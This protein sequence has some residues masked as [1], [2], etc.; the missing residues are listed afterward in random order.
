MS[1]LIGIL[2]DLDGTL[3]NTLADIAG[4]VNLVRQQY[5]LKRLTTEVVKGYI[6][7]G[8]DHLIKHSFQDLSTFDPTSLHKQV[9][10]TYLANPHLG[11]HVYPGVKEMLAKLRA[12]PHLKL[13]IAT[14]KP[15]D[16]A[17]KTL[18][19]Y[20]PET[21]FEV[22]AG[23]EKVSEKKPSPIHLLEVIER[24]NLTPQ[25]AVYVGDDP[26]DAQCAQAAGVSFYA[27]GWGYGGVKVTKERYLARP[28][29]LLAKLTFKH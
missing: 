12:N 19:Y 24:L 28:D 7:H 29:E 13:A 4:V 25:D 23:P 2:F 5:G 8:V 20:L 6:G 18:A 9:M 27:A 26:V 16:A 22:V 11:G 15:T 14:N 10:D 17:F 21:L 1:G 3:V